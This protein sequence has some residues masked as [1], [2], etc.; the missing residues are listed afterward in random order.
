MIAL[1]S[2]LGIEVYVCRSFRTGDDVEDDA[3]GLEVL[4]DI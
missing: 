4:S 3:G 2:L 1:P